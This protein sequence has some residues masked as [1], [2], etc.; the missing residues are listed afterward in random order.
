MAESLMFSNIGL[1]PWNISF[2][3]SWIFVS[4][5]HDD[6]RIEDKVNRGCETYF[7]YKITKDIV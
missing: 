6:N 3:I 2:A 1:R 7:S 5:P 4:Y